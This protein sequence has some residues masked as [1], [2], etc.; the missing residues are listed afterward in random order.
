MSL[1]SARDRY[2][3]FG[4]GERRRTG[5]GVRVG[6][7]FPLDPRWTR[8][9]VGYSI[10]ETSYKEAEGQTGTIF[11]QP[12]A[13]QSTVSTG[14]VRSTLD[15]PL[16]PTIGSRQSLDLEF[17]GGPLGG[18]GD[19][20]KYEASSNWFVPVGT[21]GGDAPGARPV[22]FT[23]GLSANM[24][25][26]MGDPTRFP[27][28]RYWMGGVQFGKPLRGYDETT[29]TP[30]GYVDRN[31]PGVS[32]TSRFGDAYLRLSAEYAVRFNDNLSL[33]LFYDAGNVWNEPSEIDPTRLFRGAGVGLMLVTPFGPIGLDYAYGFD[34]DV[35]GWQ[36]HFKFGQMF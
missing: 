8:W 15:H 21:L 30:T 16:F 27:F 26:L 17:N 1:F 18:D 12:D 32:L 24:G 5:I 9:Y 2:I 19:F 11:N 25:V 23:L 20:Q 22:R 28:E 31:S 3:N 13:L 6:Y 36:L 4:E 14:L 10:A 33:G 35:P 7:P 34:K 29:I